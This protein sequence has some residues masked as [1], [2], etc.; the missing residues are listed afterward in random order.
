MTTPTNTPAYCTQNAGFCPS[1]SLVNYGHD[2]ANYPL[3]GRWFKLAELAK[4][5][6]GDNLTAAAKLINDTGIKPRLDEIDPDPGAYVARAAVIDLV[7]MRPGDIVG[8]R[9]ASLLS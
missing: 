7:A 2:C 1:C 3:K 9:A 4:T 6:T 8:R 5:I